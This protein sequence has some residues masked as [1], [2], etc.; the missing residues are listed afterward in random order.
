VVKVTVLVPVPVYDGFRVQIL[1]QILATL[2]YIMVRI[3]VLVPV[4]VYDGFRVQILIQ[5]LA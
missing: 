2:G 4:P 1:I 5:I 3:A